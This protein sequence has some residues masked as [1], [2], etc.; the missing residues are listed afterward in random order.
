MAPYHDTMRHVP[1]VLIGVLVICIAA[2]IGVPLILHVRAV[3]EPTPAPTATTTPFDSMHLEARGA[4][5]FDVRNDT[6]L[7]EKNADEQLP[8]ASITKLL[9]VLVAHE[10]FPAGTQITITDQAL[11]EDGDSGLFS[12]ERWNI[13]E[14]LKFILTTSSND[15]IT[16]IAHAY[17]GA[18]GEDFAP[19]LDRR[20]R[21]IG[22]TTFSIRTATGLDAADTLRA[23]NFGSARDVATL[24]AYALLTIPDIL[25]ATREGTQTF[26]SLDRT[27]RI[28]NTN[29]IIDRIPNAVGGKTGFTDAA[30]GNLVMSFDR[31][32]GSPIIIVVL[33]SSKEGRFTDMQQLI[34]IARGL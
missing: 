10:V 31:S 26:S 13:T 15:G 30:G 21:E 5:V 1:Y 28:E 20:A 23:T 17:K 4:I 34:D 27:H 32:I 12:G 24:F 29:E 18:F 7:Y 9:S 6:V 3:A 33:G 2:L 22:L 8:L 16:A 25:D 11:A 14:L 19:V